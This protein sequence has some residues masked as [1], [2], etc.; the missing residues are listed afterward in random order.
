MAINEANRVITRPAGAD[1]SAQQ[2]RF[3]KLDSSGN[4]VAIAAVTDRSIGVLQNKPTSGQAAEIAIDGVVKV[5]SGI[6]GAIAPAAVIKTDASGKASNVAV[7]TTEFQLGVA[8]N[9]TAAVDQL[10]EVL[11]QYPNSL[12]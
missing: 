12:A 3:V 2:F 10:V 1:L 6:A 4:V 5:K 7:A 9:A 11:L 8:L